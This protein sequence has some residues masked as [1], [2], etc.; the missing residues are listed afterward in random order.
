RNAASVS[1][2]PSEADAYGSYLAGRLAA[3]EHDVGDAAKLFRES[4]AY[5]PNNPDLLN[6][7]LLYTAGAGNLDEAAKLAQ[8]VVVT[9][10]DDRIARLALAVAAIK[11]HDFREA[12]EQIDKSAKGA[13]TALTLSLLDAW[14]AQGEGNTDA[15]LAALKD[16]TSEGG[17]AALHT[18]HRALILD[19]AGHDQEAD[20]A[21]R[22]A[23]KIAPNSPRM[24][25]AYGRFLERN[26]RGSDA[27]AFYGKYASDAALQPVIDAARARLAAGRPAE[28]LVPRPQDGAAEALFGIA[29]SLSDDASAD[30]AILY[31]RFALSLEPGLDLAKIVLADRLEAIKKY[32]DAIAAYRTISAD[33]PYRFA[34]AVQIAVDESRLDHNDQAIADLI[35]LTAERPNDL[36]AWTALGDAYRTGEKYEQAAQA[37]DH[38]VK[39]VNP[40]TEKDW[41]LFYARGVAEERSHHWAEAERDLQYALKLSPA[42]PQVLNYLG[43]SWVD[44]GRNLPDAVMMLEKARSLSPYDGYITDSVGWAYFRL[45]RYQDAAKTL[46]QAVL[47]VPGDPT[48]NEHLG[49][50][51]WMTGRKLDAQFQWN[52]ALAFGPDEKQK[53][54]IEK[55]LQS[56]LTA[57][58]KNG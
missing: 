39:L 24:V 2:T 16:V 42:Q 14:S 47:L 56:G 28:R 40:V 27:Q 55:K 36:T 20:A 29:A 44:Q 26:G 10:P 38:A 54:A 7:A 1:A 35:S 30:V 46:E 17:T 6:R 3:S 32:E 52:H 13:F 37:Y 4:L 53:A 41:P 23:L 8:R 5:D 9:T 25:E 19:L 49:D 48:V 51:Y 22:E 57:T 50:A 34:A 18:Y 31:L 43:Y 33:S 11:R 45:G 12:R 21:Y 58:A 15:A